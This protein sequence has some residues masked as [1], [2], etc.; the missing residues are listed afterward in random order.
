MANVATTEQFILSRI[1]KN[2]EDV[3]GEMRAIFDLAESPYWFHNEGWD[4][5]SFGSVEGKKQIVLKCSYDGVINIIKA[6]STSK[7]ISSSVERAKKTGEAKIQKQGKPHIYLKIGAQTIKFEGTKGT[8]GGGDKKPSPTTMTKMQE[9]GSAWVFY[10][11]INQGKSW[12]DGYEMKADDEVNTVISKIWKKVGNQNSVDT[13]W[14]LNW[15]AQQGGLVDKLKNADA[16]C[17]FDMYTHSNEYKL[18]GMTGDSFMDFIT[19]RVGKM[20]VSGKDNWNPADIWLIKSKE[21]AAARKEI[22]RILNNSDPVEMKRDKVNEYMR[23]LF[24]SHAIFGISL[25]KVT[26]EKAS[27]V[28][29]NHNTSFFTTDWK[30]QGSNAG[31][32]N[33]IMSYNNSICKCGKKLDGDKWTMETQDMIWY[34]KDGSDSYKFQIKGNNS[35]SFSGMKY[36]PTAEG[37]GEAR[38]GKATVE[39]VL[40]NLKKHNVGDKFNKEK[41]AYPYTA[42][43][44]VRNKGTNAGS[45]WLQ[46]IEC[47]Y[48]NGVDMGEAKNAQEAY[49]NL[50]AVYDQDNG[51]PHH[52]NAKLQEIRW[53]CAFFAIKG[54][55]QRKSFA[56]DMVWLAMKAG[57]AYGPYAKVY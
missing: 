12:A 27:V 44:F 9:L 15:H 17:Q 5:K 19:K 53:L 22:D 45:T 13:E 50:L 3:F 32:D 26:K 4:K 42:D 24:Q 30:G 35:T 54:E 46:M 40:D 49:D 21:E 31:T 6:K 57:R 38:L 11:A 43:E 37:H 52:A 8:G 18:P 41:N 2:K 10:Q 51:S 56:T 7:W 14:Y 39:L 36:E 48:S 23:T 28:Y 25:K 29:F 47:L 55:K 1:H 34:V 20:G 16:C 33:A